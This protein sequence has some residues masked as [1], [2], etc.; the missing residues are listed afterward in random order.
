MHL[1]ELD[2]GSKMR[3]LLIG[4]GSVLFIVAPV[5]AQQAQNVAVSGNVTDTQLFGA[6]VTIIIALIGGGGII[7]AWVNNRFRENDA[8]RQQE[9]AQSENQTELIKAINTLGKGM[10][11]QAAAA[12]KDRDAAS[13]DRKTLL[14]IVETKKTAEEGRKDGITK[15]NDYT[16]EAADGVIKKVEALDKKVESVI[17]TLEEVHSAAVLQEAVQGVMN[18]F[19]MRLEAAIQDMRAM[20]ED[21]PPKFE[22]SPMPANSSPDRPS[23]EKLGE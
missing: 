6:V 15:I 2:I 17:K 20:R 3:T 12:A 16:S 22:L 4:I 1:Q 19:V 5:S 8:K 9:I 23:Q 14:D 10:S 7:A 21:S 13:T 18:P 11:D